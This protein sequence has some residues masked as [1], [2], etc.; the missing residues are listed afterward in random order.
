L[1]ENIQEIDLSR[2]TGATLT[3]DAAHIQSMTQN[4]TNSVVG[5]TTP[6]VLIMGQTGEHVSFTD[7]GWTTG[8]TQTVAT[9]D[10]HSDSY[11]VYS[12]TNAHVQVLVQHN[13]SASHV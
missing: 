8:S 7:S 6:S 3:L 2:V 11:T 10:G 12:N 13:M 9:P 5:G 1:V 4:A